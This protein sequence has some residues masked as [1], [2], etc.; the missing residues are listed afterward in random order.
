MRGRRAAGDVTPGDVV[1]PDQLVDRTSGRTQTYVESGAVHTQF[2]DPYCRR[3]GAVGAASEPS[4]KVG[5]AMTDIAVPRFS[6]RAEKRHYGAEGWTL[7]NMTGQPEAVLARGKRTCYAAIALVPDMDAGVEEGAG[8]GQEEGFALFR[9]NL[10]R[11]RRLLTDT[12]AVLPSPEG[13]PCSTWA[14]GLDLSYDV[15]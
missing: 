7:V 2:A 5:D 4:V 14:D 9:D 15:P 3:L 10:E 12:V 1:V 6:A 8:V 11:L 13:C